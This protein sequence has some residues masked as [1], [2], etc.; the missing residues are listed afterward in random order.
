MVIIT[1]KFKIGFS[2]LFSCQIELKLVLID[3][4]SDFTSRKVIKTKLFANFRD[5]KILSG[6]YNHLNFKI[7]FS[8]LLSCR[9]ELKIV[10]IDSESNFTPRKVF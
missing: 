1:E 5:F 8:K 9:I 10:L 3:S 4:K 6:Y 7:E 2:K